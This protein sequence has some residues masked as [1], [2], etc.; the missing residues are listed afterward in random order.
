MRFLQIQSVLLQFAVAG[1]VCSACVE[2]AKPAQIPFPQTLSPPSLPNTTAKPQSRH[3]KYDVLLPVGV[4]LFAVG[5]GVLCYFKC[6]SLPFGAFRHGLTHPNSEPSNSTASLSH[7][8]S[9]PSPEAL[10]PILSGLFSKEEFWKF[11]LSWNPENVHDELISNPKIT[12][13]DIQLLVQ[14]SFYGFQRGPVKVVFRISLLGQP[15]IVKIPHAIDE[16]VHAEAQQVLAIRYQNYQ[17]AQTIIHDHH[18]DRLILPNTQLLPLAFKKANHTF[19]MG[20]ILE[21]DLQSRWP[22]ATS[23][24]FEEQKTLYEQLYSEMNTNKGLFDELK[25]LMRQL[26]LFSS[27]TGLWDL[28]YDNVP[29]VYDQEQKMWKIV[30]VDLEYYRSDEG[31]THTSIDSPTAEDKK[32]SL[33][34]FL[35]GI[36]GKPSVV[37]PEFHNVIK[38]VFQ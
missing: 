20:A 11:V 10:T 1:L 25:E 13:D 8:S 36:Y 28:K 33:D 2:Q 17:R 32:R 37:A 16:G 19:H 4:P 29:L 31:E 26:A 6:P 18:L 24:G 23:F 21:E 9:M 38:A 30:L 22:D 15:L 35:N 5:M 7:A 14:P 34:A 27:L 3:L 12:T